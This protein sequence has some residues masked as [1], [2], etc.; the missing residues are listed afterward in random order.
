MT[1]RSGKT[2]ASFSPHAKICYHS[3]LKFIMCDDI[4]CRSACLL[5]PLEK[6]S[7]QTH[8]FFNVT[9]TC[10]CQT[11]WVCYSRANAWEQFC[12]RKIILPA[13]ETLVS[14][15]NKVKHIIFYPKCFSMQLSNGTVS[16]AI[17][18]CWQA[19]LLINT[20][21]TSYRALHSRGKYLST[22]SH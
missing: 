4:I 1:K 16:Y 19:W 3:I 18:S 12:Q 10:R 13:I 5:P 6:C 22:A 8:I 17:P 14:A 20:R 21:P 9:H 2:G 7:I 11:T 15:V